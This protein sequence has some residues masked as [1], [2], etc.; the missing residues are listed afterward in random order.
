MSEMARKPGANNPA[1]LETTPHDS[2]LPMSALQGRYSYR[3]GDRPLEGYT[4]KRAIGRGGFGEVYYATSDAGREVALK[5]IVRNFEIERRGVIQCMNLKCPNLVS[6]FDLKAN[7]DG[8]S[9][10]IMEYVAGPSL[11][12]IL[13]ENPAG[14]PIDQVHHWWKGMVEGVAY[15]HDHGIV[16]RDLKPAN[17]FLEDGVVKIGDYGLSKLMTESQRGGHSDSIGTCHYMAPEI[18]R[19]QYDKTIDL[20][21]LGIILHEMLTGRVPFEG[22]SVGEVLMKHLTDRPDLGRVPEPYRSLIAR[23]LAKDPGLRPRGALELLAILDGQPGAG[24]LPP[25]IPAADGGDVLRIG[26]DGRAEEVIYIGPD[27]VPPRPATGPARRILRGPRP[28]P[29]AGRGRPG[30]GAKVAAAPAARPSAPPPLP[31]G[32]IRIAELAGSMT[33]AA[34]LCGLLA[35]PTAAILDLDAFKRPA[36]LAFV[37]LVPLL[38]TWAWL[39]ANKLQE[40]R[41]KRRSWSRRF[42][43][44][45]AVGLA[46]GAFGTGLAKWTDAEVPHHWNKHTV[47]AADALPGGG[48]GLLASAAFFAAGLAALAPWNLI[49][50]ERPSRFR[51]APVF[52][53]A[54]IGAGLGALWPYPEPWGAMALATVAAVAQLASPWE[55]AASAYAKVDR[56]W[57]A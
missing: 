29:P 18:S 3:S 40:G 30:R 46:A 31:S 25:P 37:G 7:D 36:Q 1:L 43:T 52:A 24:Q 12:Q 42:L 39:A 10:V 49:G 38:G 9:F 14:L 21:A 50:R 53:A 45:G 27:T 33:L 56:R 8:E 16:H 17:L 34:V 55:G 44:A 20:Y 13:H 2:D 51:L 54:A 4:I 48:H 19:G 23:C 28:A 6:V 22:Q 32:R 57:A 15:L 35:V 5:L 11:A 41:G 26:P 47:V